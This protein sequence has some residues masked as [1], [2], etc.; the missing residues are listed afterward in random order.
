VKALLE[1]SRATGQPYLLAVNYHYIGA[2]DRYPHRGIVGISPAEFARQLGELGR[3]VEFVGARDIDLAVRGVRS[4]PDKAAVITFDD[5]LREQFD[6]ALPILEQHKIPF[7]FFIN[8]APLAER[9]PCFIHK[10]HYLRSVVAPEIFLSRVHAVARQELSLALPESDPAGVPPG[11]YPYDEPQAR[12]LKYLLNFV[13]PA[14]SSAAIVDRIFREY[15]DDA[16]FCDWF[17]LGK[18]EVRELQG[19]FQAVG[20]H[21]HSHR[22]LASLPAPEARR[23]IAQCAQ[24]LGEI[25]GAPSSCISY[26]YGYRDAVSRRV[27]QLARKSSLSFGFTMEPCFNRELRRD[28]LLLGRINNNEAPGHPQAAFGFVLDAPVILDPS[29]M[30]LSRSW[31]ASDAGSPAASKPETG[32]IAKARNLPCSRALPDRGQKF[33]KPVADE[34]GT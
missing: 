33:P 18:R 34:S 14:Q 12:A 26:P 23:E 16:G 20:L 32:A 10:L 9:R 30:S 8:S 2:S 25:A 13:L 15:S 11:Y 29:R 1:P 3:Q 31:F 5:G 4:L 27:A 6:A 19:R 7:I 24:I 28:P 21:G 22:A 17:Y